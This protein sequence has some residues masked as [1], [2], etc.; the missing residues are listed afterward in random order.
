MYRLV[1]ERCMHY[2]NISDQD[3]YGKQQDCMCWYECYYPNCIG[4]NDQRKST[5]DKRVDR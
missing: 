5:T 2:D 3:A 1:Q 4:W